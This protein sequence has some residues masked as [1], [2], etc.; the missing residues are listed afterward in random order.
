MNL[1]NKLTVL[2]VILVP[3]FV[4]FLLLSMTTESMKWIALALFVIAS[5]TDLLDGKIARSRNLK[6]ALT[7]LVSRDITIIERRRVGFIGSVINFAIPALLQVMQRPEAPLR[8]PF[9]GNESI[10]LIRA[11]KR[12]PMVARAEGISE[13]PRNSTHA[14]V[15]RQLSH[16]E[17]AMHHLG[18]DL[19]RS[20]ENA[21]CNCQ[22][23]PRSRLPQRAWRQIHEHSI[24]RHRK[25]R[26]AKRRDHAMLRLLHGGIDEPD[27][28][29]P[30]LALADRHFHFDGNRLDADEGSAHDRA[31][32]R[33]HS[34]QNPSA[35][36]LQ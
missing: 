29:E 28:E 21:H 12:K 9:D 8:L 35:N 25:P 3:F 7:H 5:L 22:I 20:G 24:S 6:R 11:N 32:F 2:R 4:V 19:A 23:E 27:D 18:R 26:C 36:A 31:T 17:R 15:E 33:S 13:K 14:P 1:P 16:E 10:G 30:W 34:H